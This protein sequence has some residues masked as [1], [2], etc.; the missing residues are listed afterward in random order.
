[1]D[2]LNNMTLLQGPSRNA[3]TKRKFHNRNIIYQGLSVKDNFLKEL[4]NAL[5]TYPVQNEAE[6]LATSIT[7]MNGVEYMNINYL[8][9]ALFL[10]KSN[11]IELNKKGKNKSNNINK[12]MFEDTVISMKKI[13][14]RLNDAYKSDNER[15]DQ[16]IRR[17]QNILVYLT[18]ILNYYSEEHSV[19]NPS[20]AYKNNKHQ[21]EDD[22][23][24]EENYLV[25]EL[26]EGGGYNDANSSHPFYDPEG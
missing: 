16:W 8:A 21:I 4:T 20:V 25:N 26:A 13:R 22:E 23:Q 18:V 19:Y 15:S 24:D 11:A 3:F 14:E 12:K 6:S 7:N 10:Y 9:A 17:K 2:L 1:M 5:K